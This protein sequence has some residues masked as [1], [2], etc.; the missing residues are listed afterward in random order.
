MVLVAHGLSQELQLRGAAGP[1]AA[2]SLLHKQAPA[3][4]VQGFGPCLCAGSPRSTSHRAQLPRHAVR[5]GSAPAPRRSG[6]EGCRAARSSSLPG[7]G[8]N[9]ECTLECFS[10]VAPWYGTTQGAAW[11]AMQL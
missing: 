6:T 2:L 4:V 1:G 11:G 5:R 10:E 9:T 8:R 7:L 3:L